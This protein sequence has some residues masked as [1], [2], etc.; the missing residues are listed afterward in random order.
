VSTPQKVLVVGSGSIAKRHLA[1]FRQLLPGAEVACVSASGRSLAD[2]ETTATTQLQSMAAAIVWSPDLA[3]VASPAPLHLKHARQLLEAGVPVLIE[4]PLS[5]SLECAREVAPLFALHSDRIE[6]AYN[7]R[8]L[9]SSR[10]MKTLIDDACVGR[11]LGLQ[12]EVG[13]YLPDWR[14]QADYRR[15]VSANRSLGGGVLL[16][17][18]HELDYLTWLFGRFD[19]VFCIANNSGQLE[20]DVEDR[21]DILLSRGDLTAQVH[22]DFLQRRA[23]RSCKV[24]GSTGTLHWDLIA[25]RILLE[26][27]SGDEV[28]FSDPSVDRNDMYIELLRGFIELAAG[29]AAP[30]ISLDDGLMVLEMIDAM[31]K[32]AASGRQVSLTDGVHGASH[33]KGNLPA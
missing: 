2:G 23:N 9:S 12:I 10:R 4:K 31:R 33:H 27:P 13:Q 30:R 18:S 22:M 8:F 11:I 25:N 6:V 24:I 19:K 3:V 26:Q 7:L 15:Q 17:L 28:L 20:I 29:R 32:S 14:P 21:A 5:D 16:E 1:N